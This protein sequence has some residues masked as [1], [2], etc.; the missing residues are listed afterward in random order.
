MILEG[1]SWINGP[2]VLRESSFC[3]MTSFEE[4]LILP[5]TLTVKKKR[6]SK[7]GR[8]FKDLLKKTVNFAP[9]I[10]TPYFKDSLF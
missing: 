6:S 7:K 4:N 8:S 3:N 2:C 1:I 5:F 9:Y 10:K